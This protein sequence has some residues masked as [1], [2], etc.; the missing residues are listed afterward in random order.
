MT[1]NWTRSKIERKADEITS[2]VI[3]TDLEE[4]A[5][6]FGATI[7]IEKLDSDVSGMLLTSS[8]SS[9]KVILVNKDNHENRRRFTIAH[10]IAH[11]LMHENEDEVFVDSRGSATIYFRSKE[12][13]AHIPLAERQANEFASCILMPQKAVLNY[14]KDNPIDINDDIA[15]K[16]MA[17]RFGVSIQALSIRLANLKLTSQL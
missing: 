2:G 5:K 4:I 10:E 3:P 13:I 6:N 12:S 17:N 8:K 7:R 1:S 11:L 9:K 15:V 14:I 16:V